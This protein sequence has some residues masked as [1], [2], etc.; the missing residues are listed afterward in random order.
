[1]PAHIRTVCGAT[2]DEKERRITIWPRSTDLQKMVSR[3]WADWS[4]EG[5]PKI[6]GWSHHASLTGRPSSDQNLRWPDIACRVLAPLND[7]WSSQPSDELDLDA[8]A[9]RQK[10]WFDDLSTRRVS[11]SVHPRA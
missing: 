11:W 1:M 9:Q 3:V 5:Y 2:I 7:L 8:I 10:E 6:D 4:V